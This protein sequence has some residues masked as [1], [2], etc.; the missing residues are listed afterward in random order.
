MILI[1]YKANYNGP[2]SQSN[3]K[4]SLGSPLEKNTRLRPTRF[5]LARFLVYI[6]YSDDLEH[7]ALMIFG[8]GKK[9]P[10]MIYCEDRGVHPQECLYEMTW[11][12][13]LDNW[14]NSKINRQSSAS[15]ELPNS[16]KLFNVFVKLRSY[17]LLYVLQI[18]EGQVKIV[19][20]RRGSSSHSRLATFGQHPEDI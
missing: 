12:Y 20:S 16:S 15:C 17:I 18:S 6:S 8:G 13:S 11:M 10:A 2:W 3:L 7:N 1:W 5:S 9:R 14:R 19:C 4:F